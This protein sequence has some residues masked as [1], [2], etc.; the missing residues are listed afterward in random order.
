MYQ[1]LSCLWIQLWKTNVT[2]N[3]VSV[4]NLHCCQLTQNPGIIFR[5][6]IKISEIYYR[7]RTHIESTNTCTIQNT[8]GQYKFLGLVGKNKRVMLVSTL[9][10]SSYLQLQYLEVG[11]HAARSSEA[12]NCLALKKMPTFHGTQMF[13]AVLH[14]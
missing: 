12:S 8:R 2:L 13:S 14:I 6:S 11:F 10:T 5:A 1:L 3:E 7:S 9:Q 4:T